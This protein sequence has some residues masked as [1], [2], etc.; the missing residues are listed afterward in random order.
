MPQL[1]RRIMSRSSTIIPSR[2]PPVALCIGVLLATGCSSPDPFAAWTDGPLAE[3]VDRLSRADLSRASV[4]STE[5]GEVQSE[6]V[7]KDAGP[8]WYVRQALQ[9]NAGIR[10]ARQRVERLRERIPQATA[11]PDPMASVTFGQLAETAAGQVDYIIG[12]Q[13]SLPFPG[14]LDARGEVARQEVVEALHDLQ[15]TIDRVRGDTHRAYWSHFDASTEIKV[16]EQNQALLAQI[17]SAVRSRLRV[18]R[19]SQADLLR[20]SRRLA[21]LDN[22]VSVLHQRRTTASAMLARLMS[23]PVN[24]SLT[25]IDKADWRARELDRDA[26]LRRGIH[27]NPAVLAAQARVATFQRRLALARRER[28]PD[29][30]VGVQYGVVSESG[31]SPVADGKDQIAATVGMSIPLWSGRYDAAERE[32]LRGM[33]EALAGV[34]AAQDRVAFEI[35]DSLARIEANEQS[36]RRLRERMMPSARQTVEVALTGYRTGDVDFLQLLDDWQALLDDQVEEARII[37]ELNRSLADLEQALG[38]ELDSDPQTDEP[39][40][41]TQPEGDR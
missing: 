40:A 26:L 13:Q 9:S 37:A 10:A 7:P 38:G 18:G 23:R 33:G 19:A 32:A 30:Q 17:E 8:D 12:V 1:T 20:V 11:L 4:V 41:T 29:F 36:L 24:V 35:D 22:Q 28:Q 5:H 21:A 15:A 2:Y 3:R 25:E 6:P 39:Q 14:T 27:G 34:R 31:L 16:L